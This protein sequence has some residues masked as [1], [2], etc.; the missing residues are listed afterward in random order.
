M[1]DWLTSFTLEDKK[2]LKNIC[3]LLFRKNNINHNDIS[4]NAKI[5]LIDQENF[6]KIKEIVNSDSSLFFNTFISKLIQ[7]EL[8]HLLLQ[9]S[10]IAD[11]FLENLSKTKLKTTVKLSESMQFHTF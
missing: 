6:F 8:L 4:Y 3:L 1:T 7:E 2:H 9:K 5:S 11:K 10:L